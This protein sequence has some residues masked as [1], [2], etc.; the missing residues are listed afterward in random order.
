MQQCL[1]VE[2]TQKHRLTTARREPGV[3][4]RSGDCHDVVHS[5]FLR[6]TANLLEQLRIDLGCVDGSARL[7]ALGDRD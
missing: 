1:T 4:F 6:R 2:L 3:V 7:H 5:R